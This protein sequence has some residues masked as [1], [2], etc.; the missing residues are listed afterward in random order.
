MMRI[1]DVCVG[2]YTVEPVRLHSPCDRARSGPQTFTPCGD[3]LGAFLVA[4]PG[5]NTVPDFPGG[6]R[7]DF[8]GGARPPAPGAFLAKSAKK[9]PPGGRGPPPGGVPGGVLRGGPKR[10]QKGPFLTPPGG[11]PRGPPPRGGGSPQ[12]RP[13][14][15]AQNMQVFALIKVPKKGIFGGCSFNQPLIREGPGPKK[16]LFGPFW[17]PGPFPLK[18][19][20]GAPG[21]PPGGGS[22]PEGVRGG[23][24]GGVREGPG[25]HF[26]PGAR[27]W[28]GPRGEGGGSGAKN[29]THSLPD[30][31]NNLISKGK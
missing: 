4:P 14:K 27:K 23:G 22:G 20:P 5:K 10:A 6:A 19:L 12:G 21:G 1:V 31:P 15:L 13:P 28:G 18:G 24:P 29:R 25:P 30:S 7:P 11:P 9:G 16:A 8:P 26:R 3:C 17:G 2:P